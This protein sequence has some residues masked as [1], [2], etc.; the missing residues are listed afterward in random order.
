[1]LANG[2]RSGA[3][4]VLDVGCGAGHTALA[5]A[6]ACAEVVALDLT[7]AMLE[8]TGALA[9]RRGLGNVS[10]QQGDAA[11]LP[12]P[13]GRFD[14]VTSRLCAH[15]YAAPQQAVHEAARV[16]APGG[17]FLLS[18]TVAPEDPA[19]DSFLNAF[20]LLRDSSHVRD[21]RISEWLA[22]LRAAG[23]EARL[24]GEWKIQQDFD[25]WV[26]RIG[27]PSDAVAGLR[28]LFDHA[29]EEVRGAYGIR[30]GGD[31]AFRLDLAVIAGRKRA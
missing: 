15:H 10:L 6:A 22:M 21:H 7:E 23:F 17:L 5:F 19:R 3:E 26:Q 14:V 12:F 1:M 4:R 18:D 31:Y 28:A 30:G 29:P 2:V 9:R 25:A 20:E 11:A 27:T 13:E 8:Q 24:L 16:L